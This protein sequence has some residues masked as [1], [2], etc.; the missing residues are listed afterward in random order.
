MQAAVMSYCLRGGLAEDKRSMEDILMFA[1]REE[2][3]AV[4]IY[5][6]AWDTEGDVRKAA[7]AIRPTAERLGVALPALGSGTRL[8]HIDSSREANMALLKAEVEACALIGGHVMTLPIVDGQPVAKDKANSIV[9]IRFEQMLPE[10][11]AQL[12]ELSDHAARFH[13]D[14]AVLNHCFLVYLGWHQKWLTLLANRENVGACVDPG[15][16]LHYGH[17]NPEPVCVALASMAKMARAGNV[18]PTPEAEV[19]DQF[20]QKGQ[21][22]PWQAAPFDAGV[23]DQAACYRALAQGG[24]DGVVSLKTAG[25]HPDGAAAA[26]RAS[27]QGLKRAVAK[28]V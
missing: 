13:V 9:G 8:G 16:Y 15:N 25:S 21:F 22:N 18:M 19:I 12:H 14:L 2:I 20:R 28:A 23:I 10:L 7:E 3:S 5:A 1:H 26:I 6:G 11:V 4:E 24:F 17:E 27:W